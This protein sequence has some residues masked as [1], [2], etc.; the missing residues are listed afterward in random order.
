MI[1]SKRWECGPTKYKKVSGL[2]FTDHDRIYDDAMKGIH[3]YLDDEFP[4]V[5]EQRRVLLQHIKDKGLEDGYDY[6]MDYSD[7]EVERI[8]LKEW[9][10]VIRTHEEGLA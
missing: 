7:K 8:Y 10:K 6:C 2:V 9:N 1:L 4:P 3:I 5:A